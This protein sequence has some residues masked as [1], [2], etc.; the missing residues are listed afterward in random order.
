MTIAIEVDELIVECGGRFTGQ[1][2]RDADA[3]GVSSTS[4]ARS[5]RLVL[6]FRTEGRGDTDTSDVSS[7]QFDLEPHGGMSS[8]FSLAVPASAPVS[9]DGRTMRIL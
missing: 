4:K 1:V 5:V 6:R 3:D 2:S 8:P 9:Y 7:L